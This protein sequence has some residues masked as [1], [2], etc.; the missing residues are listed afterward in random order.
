MQCTI[1]HYSSNGFADR[2]TERCGSDLRVKKKTTPTSRLYIQQGTLVVPN[3]PYPHTVHVQ[4]LHYADAKCRAQRC[5]KRG[6]TVVNNVRI[7][8]QGLHLHGE[9]VR[10]VSE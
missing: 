1:D 9:R 2:Q 3:G 8:R 5:S 4:Y 6:E 10:D 7:K